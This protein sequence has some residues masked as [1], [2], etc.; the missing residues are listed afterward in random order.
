MPKYETVDWGSAQNVVN[1]AREIEALLDGVGDSGAI[2]SDTLRT[3]IKTSWSK[4]RNGLRYSAK[5]S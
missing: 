5:N 4:R 1:I 2:T 3:S